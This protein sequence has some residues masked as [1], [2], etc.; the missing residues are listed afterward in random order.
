MAS[1][2]LQVVAHAQRGWAVRRQST[3]RD[4]R[5]FERKCDAVDFGVR[6]AFYTRSELVITNRAGVVQSRVIA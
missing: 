6:E 4:L 5:V 2:I 1:R 3:N